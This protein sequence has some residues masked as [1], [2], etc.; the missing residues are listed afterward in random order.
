VRFAA[1]TVDVSVVF[2]ERDGMPQMPLVASVRAVLNPLPST[3][4]AS[5]YLAPLP[6]PQLGLHAADLSIDFDPQLMKAREP[7]RHVLGNHR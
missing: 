5:A 6:R 4:A 3:L 2:R 7:M 1:P